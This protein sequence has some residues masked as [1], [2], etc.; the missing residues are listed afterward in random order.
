MN[1][2]TRLKVLENAY[3]HALVDSTYNFSKQGVLDKVIEDKKKA[4]MIMGKKQAEQFGM[5]KP[6]D[7]FTV[8][9][10]VFNCT[11]WKI[12]QIDNG[13]QAKSNGCKL[14]AYAKKLGSESPCYIY[15]LNPMVG[16][17]KGIDPKLNFEV[18][19]TLWD[20]EEC[21]IN[22]NK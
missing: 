14:C 19:E 8:L 5:T 12:K 17:I 6:E 22:V 16:M 1:L 15:C 13:F 21:K 10:K 2:E 3:I 7:V 11:S 9:S 20:G 4:Q 18:K